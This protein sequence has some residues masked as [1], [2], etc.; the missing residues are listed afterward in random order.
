MA[1]TY[2]LT[3]LPETSK[4]AP[5]IR[6]A[7]EQAERG[8]K[9]A[10]EFDTSGAQTAGKKAGRDL[11][12]SIE[13]N[14]ADVG[15]MIRTDGARSAGQTAGREVNAGLQAANIGRGVSA[16]LETNLSRDATGIGSRVGAA[17]GRGLR[18]ATAVAGAGLTAVLGGAIASGVRRL[19]AIDDA[20]FKLR[21]LGNDTQQ[22]EA[23]MQNAKDAVLGTAFG[24]DEAATTAASAVAAGIKS[25]TELTD[26]LKL[27]AD[28]AAIAGTNLADMGA[29][30]NKVQTSGRAFTDDL[31]M[32]ADRGLP[33]FQWLQDEYH[34]TA[35]ELA[36]MVQDGKVDAQTFRKVIAENI[37]GAAQEMGGSVRGTLSNLKAA[38]SRFGAELSGPIFA[39]VIPFATSFTKVFDSLTAQLK[40]VL[41]QITAQVQPWAERTGAAISQWF[42]NGG[43]QRVVDWFVQLKDTIAGFV[44]GDSGGD[45]L[46]QL[47]AGA[48]SLGEAAKNA[49]PALQTVGS[50][51][52]AFG[53]A[54]IQVGPE[55]LTQIMVPAMNLF[56]G[57]LKFV[58][59]NANW[60]VPT[61]I[62]LGG[63][64]LG[65]KAVGS[66]VGP[67]VTLWNNI[68]NAARTPL[69]LAQNAAIRQQS[70]AM[71]QLSIALGTNT[72]QQN[73]NAESQ[74]ASVAA[75]NA[76]TAATTRGRIATIASTVAEKAKAVALRATAAAQ[77]ALNAA[78]RANPIG[79]IITAVV[80]L[81]TALWAFFTKT[82]TGRKLW[83]KIWNGIKAVA[84]PVI[85]WLKNTLSTAWQAIQPGLQKIGEI[86]KAA[87]GAL[88]NAIKT[89]WDF[90]EPAIAAFGRFY[91]A[92]VKWQF[93]NVI[94]A[95]KLV[96][97][98][99]SW[100]WQNV[101]VP[102]FQG[103]GLV[104]QTWWAGVQVVWNALTTAISFVGDKMLWL[105]Q[106][107]FVPAWEG[108]KI[109]IG[110][111]W[112]FI[113]DIFE[114]IKTGF[115][116]LKNGVVT[117]AGAIKDGITKAFSGLADIIKAPL[118]ALGT[119]LAGVP[120]SVFGVSIPGAS[121][122]KSWGQ[123]LQGLAT[124]GV[125]RG[126]GTGRSDSML[127][128]PA[129]V[130]VSNGEFVVNAAATRKFLPLLQAINSGS[131]SGLLPGFADGGLVSADDL[132]NFAKGVEGQPYK[133]GGTNW[134]D[135][136]GAVSAIANYATGRD[137]FS[138]RFATATEGAEL[139][140][141]G[142]KDGL[143]PPGSLNIGW[144]NGGPG[145]GHTAATLPNGVN[146]EMGGKRGNGQY[147]GSAAGADDPQFTNH[148]HL[149]PEYFTGLDGLSGSTYGSTSVSA[150]GG[151]TSAS[152]GGSSGTGGGSYRP[153]TDK[154]LQSSSNRVYNAQNS[155]KQAQ[156]AVDDKQYAVDKAQ[157]RVDELRAQG[158]DTTDAEHTLE[159]NQREL[160]DAHERL[161]RAEEKSAQV[162]EEDNELRTKGKFVPGKGSKSSGGEGGLD[163]KDFGK[164]FVEGVL[165]TI[166]LDGSLFSNPFEWPTVKS[167]MAGL[168][169]LGGLFK[170]SEDQAAGELGAATSPGGFAAGAAD[171]VGLGEM[172]SPLQSEVPEDFQ[173][174]TPQ[175]A[176]GQYNPATAGVNSVAGA[177]GPADVLSAFAPRGPLPGPADQQQPQ[178]VD[179]SINIQQAGMDPAALR[180]EIRA[181]QNQ[182]TRT[183][184]RR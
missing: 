170:G 151:S 99:I 120:D 162:Q 144:Y 149:P 135:C 110:A 102:A 127:G 104:I 66:T 141:R 111:A 42:D 148:M 40:P 119:F 174:G 96:G 128:Y 180:N 114:K 171:A 87:F 56:A 84:T 155:V 168:N 131:L 173:S 64:F 139:R 63:A 59:D 54:L 138:S 184:V 30:F 57:A 132:V 26:Y 147:G 15:R 137:P 7:A 136:S 60:A 106:N 101:A 98:T 27:T 34:V 77:W 81:G 160:A 29:I 49:G 83:D 146:F 157:R 153:A 72:V 143:G 154:E 58:A 23:I 112:D 44:S 2:Y 134:G 175:L 17:I 75:T 172:L 3:I 36:K 51:L 182:R 166:G 68:F 33:I 163:G 133:W 62:A 12:R 65:L 21:G 91:A 18:T 177:A 4:L 125:V 88:G 89:V 1:G 116:A 52:G 123:S 22:V 183:T 20:R 73:L 13:S 19:T 43:L 24:L 150:I 55:T 97:S 71:T 74:A 165:E 90:I 76:G 121:T 50:A 108:I 69:I 122:I 118:H 82:E 5:G 156:Q 176:P 6:K 86:A 107:V 28:T 178:V 61:I 37:G 145:G 14:G 8:L 35:E 129:M 117:V 142:F 78:L 48:A 46:Q 159:K 161:R 47:S 124:G 93:D 16:Q 31:N 126:P 113:S 181:E 115:D 32:L 80:A 105:W 53:Q 39:A 45:T 85:E 10:P 103:I 38:Y 158:K 41:E 92:L 95:L 94:T 164:T 67:L 167:A 140:K 179:N 100:L 79:L 130:R 169:F 70:A 9:V 25:G 11:A 109:G 152:S